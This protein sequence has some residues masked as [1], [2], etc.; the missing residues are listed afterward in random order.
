VVSLQR[1]K[2]LQGYWSRLHSLTV[3]R[4]GTVETHPN[5]VDVSLI[6]VPDPQ[7]SQ[8]GFGS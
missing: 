7:R 1:M 8:Q 6:A 4:S 2:V 5:E 3:K